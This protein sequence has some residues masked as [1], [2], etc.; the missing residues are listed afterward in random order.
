VDFLLHP[1]GVTVKKTAVK[2][3]DWTGRGIR[4]VGWVSR[5]QVGFTRPAHL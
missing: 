5:A 3:L 1:F 4:F 2:S